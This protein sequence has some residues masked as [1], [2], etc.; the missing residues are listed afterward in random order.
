MARLTAASSLSGVERPWRTLIA[1]VPMNAMS[2]RSV[3]STRSVCSPT[4]AWVRPRTRPPSSC[5]ETD[6]M[7]ASRAAI[8]TELVTTTSSRSAGN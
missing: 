4:A 2:T 5:R 6:G 3:S 1:L 7:A 8:G